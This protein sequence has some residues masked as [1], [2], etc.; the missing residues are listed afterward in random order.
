MTNSIKD[1]RLVGAR[2]ISEF[3]AR[4]CGAPIICLRG[5]SFPRPAKAV[6]MLHQ[7][8]RFAS[9]TSAGRARGTKGERTRT[10][11][12]KATRSWSDRVAP[13]PQSQVNEARFAAAPAM[14]NNHP[15]LAK[16]SPFRGKAKPYHTS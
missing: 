5:A 1:D 2:R 4:M 14:G 15:C 12:G 10:V 13:N 9:S 16:V 3:A 11:K 6:C 8:R 7:S